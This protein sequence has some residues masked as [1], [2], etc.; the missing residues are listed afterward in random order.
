M[1]GTPEYGHDAL[2]FYDIEDAGFTTHT[3]L[4]AGIPITSKDMD[5]ACLQ[6]TDRS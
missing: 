6:P 2:S 5:L 4:Q 1:P 3:F